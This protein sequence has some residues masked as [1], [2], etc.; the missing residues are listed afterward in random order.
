MIETVM[1]IWL[2][3][4]MGSLGTRARDA[5]SVE[6]RERLLAAAEELLLA[7]PS[8]E[9][10]VRA[11][12]AAAETNPAAVHYHFGS[13]DALVAAL[14]EAR[15]APLWTE[16]LGAAAQREAELAEVV[17]A[18]IGPLTDL[19]ADPRG[20]LYLRLL[21]ELVLGR[22]DVGWT[23]DWFQLD[24]WV[25]FLPDLDPAEAQ[26]RWLLAFE[27]L[28]MRFGAGHPPSQGSVGTL[29]DFVLAGLDGPGAR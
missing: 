21:A 14:L 5:R 27:V 12:C 4:G 22:R 16:R 13:K 25:R 7:Q 6:T 24:T 17:D 9:V 1:E 11:V 15:L 8:T 10:S 19:A 2:A 20:R 26:R 29:R 3:A 23:G 28:I 18:V